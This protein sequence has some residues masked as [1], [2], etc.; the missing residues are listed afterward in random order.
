M[1]KNKI[2]CGGF[3][4]GDG[5]NVDENGVLSTGSGVGNVIVKIKG[6]DD[7][8]YVADKSFDDIKTA[9]DD[10][11]NVSLYYPVEDEVFQLSD[12]AS[13]QIEFSR[14]TPFSISKFSITDSNEVLYKYIDLEGSKSWLLSFDDN[15]Y[16]TPVESLDYIKLKSP[17]GTLYTISVT[18]DGTIQAQVK[19]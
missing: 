9:I 7:D 11:K 6:T 14:T 4:V 19:P 18:D 5:L 10:G 13:Y 1:G 8:T 17:N 2:P 16:L 12:F 15:D 3:Y